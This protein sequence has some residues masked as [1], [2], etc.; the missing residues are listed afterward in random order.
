VTVVSDVGGEG[1]AR[2]DAHA[3]MLLIDGDMNLR[4]LH[5]ETAGKGFSRSAP[6]GVPKWIGSVRIIH[7]VVSHHS[8]WAGNDRV[9]VLPGASPTQISWQA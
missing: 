8:V 3:A 9:E 6:S 1:Q 7:K 4:P 5:R 2:A